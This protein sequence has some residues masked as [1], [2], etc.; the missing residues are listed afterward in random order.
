MKNAV[1][2][3]LSIGLSI[4]VGIVLG[5]NKAEERLVEYF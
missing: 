5:I 1:I 3:M 2:F 4:I